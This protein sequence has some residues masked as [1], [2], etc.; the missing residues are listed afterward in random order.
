MRLRGP[1]RKLKLQPT[2][3][4]YRNDS[5]M[6]SISNLSIISIWRV[7]KLLPMAVG[8]IHAS[9]PI[10]LFTRYRAR[11]QARSLVESR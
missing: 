7:V 8:G 11:R 3:I 4:F 2:L 10:V 1:A 9:N 6:L 5:I